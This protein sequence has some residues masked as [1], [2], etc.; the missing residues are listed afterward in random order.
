MVV[1]S[2]SLCGGRVTVPDDWCCMYPPTPTCESCGAEAANN[3]PVIEMIPRRTN[4]GT[5]SYTSN[6]TDI[7]KYWS[8]T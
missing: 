3:G 6:A 8:I 7:P 1:G 4:L 5:I 2:C